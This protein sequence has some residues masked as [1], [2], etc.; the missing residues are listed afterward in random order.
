MNT[1]TIGIIFAVL[2]VSGFFAFKNVKNNEVA[3][4]VT[5]FDECVRAGNPVAE[6]WPEQCFH[7]GERFV[8]DIGNELEKM[9]LIRINSPRPTAEII[10]PLTIEGEARGYW[11]FEGS[12]PVVLLDKNN[13]LI[14][15]GFATA[16][17]KWMTED[18]VSFNAELQFEV[19]S[20]NTAGTL[21]LKK[22]NPSDIPELNDELLV[23]IIFK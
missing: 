20:P 2:V 8:R 14:T 1:R 11:F 10:S 19:Q 6:S 16:E 9:D 15:E 5:S 3:I 22:D 13:T 18:F 7:E 23:P 4:V 17:G 21:V 12:F